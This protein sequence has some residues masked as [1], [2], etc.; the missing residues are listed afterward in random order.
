[1]GGLH[2]L[3]QQEEL[4]KRFGQKITLS[5]MIVKHTFFLFGTSFLVLVAGILVWLVPFSSMHTPEPS[6]STNS[7]VILEQSYQQGDSLIKAE[8]F[9]D[10]WGII[11]GGNGDGSSIDRVLPDFTLPAGEGFREAIQVSQNAYIVLSS[12]HNLYLVDKTGVVASTSLTSAG[13]SYKLFR[14]Y[15]SND[16]GVLYR[17]NSC[18]SFG[19]Y[20]YTYVRRYNASL[21]TV[22]ASPSL[23]NGWSYSNVDHDEFK[24]LIP[25]PN[26]GF[27]TIVLYQPYG[28]T[29]AMKVKRYTS[30]CTLDTSFWTSGELAYAAFDSTMWEAKG[31]NSSQVAIKTTN[32]G[33]YSWG[34]FWPRFEV[35]NLS[36]FSLAAWPINL[37]NWTRLVGSRGSDFLTPSWQI[38]SPSLT[39]V[40]VL[41]MPYGSFAIP[42]YNIGTIVDMGASQLAGLQNGRLIYYNGSATVGSPRIMTFPYQR[43]WLSHL[44]YFSGSIYGYATKSDA[45]GNVQVFSMQYSQ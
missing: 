11:T 2:G 19:C 39:Y 15:G 14:F 6:E 26:G 30:S 3:N 13:I 42:T 38:Y 34:Q 20:Y 23:A 17:V 29:A 45:S 21:G 27:Y 44:S 5:N 31:Y 18:D 25:A 12:A 32:Y 7:P 1:M 22:C 43:S 8:S 24:E 16:A 4:I 10:A 41:P 37:P 28:W 33:V 9:V 40:G 35:R 36:N